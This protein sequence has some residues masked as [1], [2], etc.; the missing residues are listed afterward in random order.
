ML[1]ALE[2]TL[3][4]QLEPSVYNNHEYLWGMK[5]VLLCFV[6]PFIHNQMR[7]RLDFLE[8]LLHPAN[9]LLCLIQ[10]LPSIPQADQD[11]CLVVIL[12]LQ[13]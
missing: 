3:F 10:D 12:A 13:N 6:N 2:I 4:K 7:R 8:L 5:C 11:R 9:H 1:T